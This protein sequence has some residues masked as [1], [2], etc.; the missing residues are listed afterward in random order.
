MKGIRK[1]LFISYLSIGMVVL[2]LFWLT[3]VV[4][5][6]RIYEYYKINQLK[7]YSEQIVQAINNNNEML[8]SELIDKSN[9]RV[10]AITENDI[11]IAGNNRGHGMRGLGI[12]EILLRPTNTTK[13]VKYEHPFL[14][15][16]YLSIVRPFLYNGK[17]AIL[18]MSLPEASINDS[19]NLFKEV[20]WW[21]F[22]LTIVST[23]VVSSYMSKKFTRPIQI[24]KNAAHEI[25]S[26]NLNVKIN[27][28]EEDELGDLAKSMNTMVKQLS[29]TDKFRKDLIA[30]I[31][32]DLKTPLGLIRGYSEMLLDYYGEDKEKR[33]KYLNTVIKET[34]RMSKLVDDVLQLSKLQ[35]GMIEVK[36]ETIDL[37]KLIFEI[38]DIF[39]IQILEKNIEVKL[40]NLKVKVV[41]DRE[42]IKRAIINII[43]NA[44]ASMENGG[45]LSITAELQD[46]NVLIK[47]SDTGCGIP[48]KD[49]E[50]IFD[51]FYKG[52]KSGT[53]LGLAIVKEILTLHQSDFGIRS[54]EGEGTTFYF[55]LKAG[56]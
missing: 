56:K 44:I 22:A 45:T 2:L 28:K 43:S 25:A 33:E 49:L 9:A 41:A 42:M 38:L 1:K 34:E 19:V 26:G 27:Y 40:E 11:V 12:P 37:E 3:Q 35:S 21:I 13:V 55:T 52:N 8:I 16:E 18:I 48:E 53:G 6:N 32:H 29:I 4:F 15:I 7:S 17:P 50:H 24:L 30:N 5:I 51:R 36:E 14:H 20:F 23:L 47:I 31:S 39:E 10:I 54:K 46:K